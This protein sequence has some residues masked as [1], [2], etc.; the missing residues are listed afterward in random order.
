MIIRI[1]LF[2]GLTYCFGQDTLWHA[3]PDAP[4]APPE[5][6]KHDDIFSQ[7]IQLAGWSLDLGRS[8]I[9]LMEVHPGWN[10]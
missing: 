5:L 9:P 8:F 3:L 2:V 7:M 6:K 4:E 1:I 10:S